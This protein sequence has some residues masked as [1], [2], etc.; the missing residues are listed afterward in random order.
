MRHGM[1]HHACIHYA[2]K[3]HGLYAFVYVCMSRTRAQKDTDT[4]RDTPTARMQDC[5][6][7]MMAEKLEMPSMP[8]LDIEKVPPCC[9]Y[10][11]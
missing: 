9:F 5:G 1:R 10:G 11:L 2:S 4:E 6:G 7:L 8:R 3:H